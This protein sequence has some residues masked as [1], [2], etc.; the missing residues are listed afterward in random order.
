MTQQSFAFGD[1][2]RHPTRPEWGVGSVTKVETVTIEGKPAQRLSVRF[3]GQGIKVLNTGYVD[4]SR[5]GD[6]AEAGS[7]LGGF[8]MDEPPAAEVIRS[9]DGADWLAD[10][11]RRR[12]EEAM[13]VLPESARDPFASAR[14]RIETTLALYRFERTGHGLI[15]W[16]IAQTGLDDPLNRFNRHELERFFDRWATERDAHLARLVAESNLPAAELDTL[17]AAA[18]PSA[19]RAIGRRTAAGR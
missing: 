15:D 8:Q 12:I 11:N 5:I 1:Q 2:V 17:M 10:V 9:L 4:L 19:L 18:P 6:E 14:R 16:A 3:P 13:R 7:T